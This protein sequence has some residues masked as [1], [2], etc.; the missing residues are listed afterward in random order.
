MKNVF[1]S[2]AATLAVFAAAALVFTPKGSKKGTPKSAKKAPRTGEFY[3]LNTPTTGRATLIE[4]PGICDLELTSLETEP[5]QGLQVWLYEGAAPAVGSDAHILAA[6]KRLV[7]GQLRTFSGN[8]R[9]AVSRKIRAD[10]YHSVVLWCDELQ[11]FVA[12]APLT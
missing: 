2:L 7:V 8:F 5:C 10:N 9:F 3:S 6:G 11:R 4:A 12:A 1:R